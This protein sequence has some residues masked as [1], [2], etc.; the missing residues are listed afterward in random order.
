MQQFK[1][2]NRWF[3][4]RY[5]KK[6]EE[7]KTWSLWGGSE[8]GFGRVVLVKLPSVAPPPVVILHTSENAIWC[9]IW[10]CPLNIMETSM[11]N[12]MLPVQ[13]VGKWWENSMWNVMLSGRIERTSSYGIVQGVWFCKARAAAQLSAGLLLLLLYVTPRRSALT[14]RCVTPLVRL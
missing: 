13:C 5:Q 4:G 8:G 6:Q 9:T 10:Y 11:Y 12:V 7:S 2:F 3:L 14:P 1:C